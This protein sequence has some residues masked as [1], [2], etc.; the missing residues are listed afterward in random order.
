MSVKIRFHISR[1]MFINSNTGH[2]PL[3][4]DVNVVFKSIKKKEFNIEKIN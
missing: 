3:I 1:Q 2:Y 4:T